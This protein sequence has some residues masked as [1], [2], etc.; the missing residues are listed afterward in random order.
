MSNKK[1]RF[2]FN[3]LVRD[4]QSPFM[5]EPGIVINKRTLD[6][7]EF[8]IELK[9]KLVEESHEV[10]VAHGDELIEEIVDLKEIL[11]ALTKAC[12]IKQ[13]AIKAIRQKKL[14][15]RGGF[16]SRTFISYVDVPLNSEAYEYCAKQH[17]K[18]PMRNLE[19]NE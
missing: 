7:D 13:E 9:R 18:Y 5:Q 14:Q 6:L 4:K 17:D 19:D 15:E 16:N 3:K 2:M 8:I 1:V 10:I 12:E 11:D